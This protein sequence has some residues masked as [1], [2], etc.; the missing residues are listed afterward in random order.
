MCNPNR[1]ART[2]DVL[3]PISGLVGT[4]VGMLVA[5]QDIAA[6]PQPPQF[7]ELTVPIAVAFGCTLVCLGVSLAVRSYVD[8]HNR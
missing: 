6:S 4:I 1:P 3:A 7:L 5:F 8:H 2:I